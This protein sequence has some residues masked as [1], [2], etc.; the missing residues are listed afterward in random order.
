MACAESSACA[1]TTLDIHPPSSVND[2]FF[3]YSFVA[4]SAPTKPPVFL[5]NVTPPATPTVMPSIIDF[6]PEAGVCAGAGVCAKPDCDTSNAAA[7]N[8][9][10]ATRFIE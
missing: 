1:L 2:V 6:D 7:A 3:Q 10:V 5:V 9:A 4:I 8:A